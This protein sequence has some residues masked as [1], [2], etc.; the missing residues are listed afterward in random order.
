MCALACSCI[1]PATTPVQSRAG[2][3]AVA[4]RAFARHCLLC[5]CEVASA[6]S[7]TARARTTNPW[8][9]SKSA[10]VHAC[11]RVSKCVL[12]VCARECACACVCVCARKC[13]CVCMCLCRP[14]PTMPLRVA[15]ALGEAGPSPASLRQRRLEAVRGRCA[16]WP[17]RTACR[18]C[19]RHSRAAGPSR[20]TS[21]R[22]ASW[23]DAFCNLRN[24]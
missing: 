17:P 2:K 5:A 19:S 8:Y 13:S 18:A 9:H 4:S 6:P 16:R 14:P 3:H 22:C 12:R 15:H 1:P 23:G 20:P 10:C 24:G 7:V 11:V 21:A